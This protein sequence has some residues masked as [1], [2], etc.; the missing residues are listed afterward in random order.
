VGKSLG[1]GGVLDLLL[2]P[3]SFFEFRE[4]ARRKEE[5]VLKKQLPTRGSSPLF[6]RG[7]WF[8]LE[9][10]EC[11]RGCSKSSKKGVTAGETLVCANHGEVA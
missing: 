1:R 8:F 6:V 2:G 5:G 4:G 10:G 11:C 9:G 7:G 3:S